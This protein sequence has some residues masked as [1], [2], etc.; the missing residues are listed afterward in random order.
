LCMSLARNLVVGVCICVCMRAFM[1]V[2]TY[3]CLCICVYVCVG[4][5]HAWPSA[6]NCISMP[7]MDGRACVC[8]HACMHAILLLQEQTTHTHTH[9]HIHTWQP[10]VDCTSVPTMDSRASKKSVTCAVCCLCCSSCSRAPS[11]EFVLVL[12][13]APGVDLVGVGVEEEGGGGVEP[14]AIKAATACAKQTGK[15]RWVELYGGVEMEG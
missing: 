12:V 15:R 14:D 4:R 9:T 1:L 13:A 7:A 2:C 11:A 6:E 10:E 3:G 8:E 5:C